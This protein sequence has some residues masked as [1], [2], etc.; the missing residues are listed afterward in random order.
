MPYDY[1]CQTTGS[2]AAI[3]HCSI[4]QAADSDTIVKS[5]WGGS[6]EPQIVYGLFFSPKAVIDWTAYMNR[7]HP[8]LLYAGVFI[9]QRPYCEFN[10][11]HSP[12]ITLSSMH[13]CRC[14]LGDL[15][16]VFTDKPAKRRVAVLLQAK[17]AG[18]KW[19]PLH[20]NPDQ[21][22]LYIGWP[23]FR[24][25]PRSPTGSPGPRLRTLPFTGS[26]DPAAHYLQLDTSPRNIETTPAL[27]PA[28]LSMWD[29][30]IN[31]LL[32]GGAGRDFSFH[33]SSAT[34]DWDQLIW[35]LLDYTYHCAMPSSASSGAGGTRGTGSLLSLN[36]IVDVTNGNGPGAR[37]PS[38]Q[39]PDDNWGIPVIH[40]IRENG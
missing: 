24:Y 29:R 11:H 21:W 36:S 28:S 39:D 30:T 18:G 35:D 23:T 37:F 13:S 22:D 26:A 19:P 38:G 17:M 8:S 12:P 14:E 33:R 40:L 20:P 32:N 16:L 27:S 6:S 34:N 31:R 9:H 1:P 15:L 25:T 2:H 7:W 10:S 5:R 3:R 4:C